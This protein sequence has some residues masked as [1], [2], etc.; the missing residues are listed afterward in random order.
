MR[1]NHD[2]CVT[3]LKIFLKR[4]RGEKKKILKNSQNVI[5]MSQKF[6][7]RLKKSKFLKN[8]QKVLKSSQMYLKN[9][10]KMQLNSVFLPWQLRPIECNIHL[11]RHAMY[12]FILLEKIKSSQK[13]SKKDLVSM[14]GPKCLCGVICDSCSVRARVR[15]LTRVRMVCQ[16]TLR[17]KTHS[18]AKVVAMIEHLECICESEKNTFELKHT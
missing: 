17:Q 1:T 2:I 13:F 4:H 15:A 9:V 5:K 6:S 16:R 11:E 7:N 3:K 12:N 8:S 10:S 18:N 14:S